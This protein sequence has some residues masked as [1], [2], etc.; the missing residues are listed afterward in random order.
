MDTNYAQKNNIQPKNKKRVKN[1]LATS[2]TVFYLQNV[3]RDN[4]KRV[5][6]QIL[7]MLIISLTTYSQL[8]N[9]TEM[10]QKHLNL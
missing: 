9:L 6:L 10:Q 5:G 1:V 7:Y 2:S 3:S 4:T 8:V